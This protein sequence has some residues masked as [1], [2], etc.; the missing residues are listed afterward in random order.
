[1]DMPQTAYWLLVLTYPIENEV[2]SFLFSHRNI[3][4]IKKNTRI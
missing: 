2:I 3:Q 1:M 4:A